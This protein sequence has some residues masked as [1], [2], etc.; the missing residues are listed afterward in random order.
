VEIERTRRG[1]AYRNMMKRF[2]VKAVLGGMLLVVR[3]KESTQISVVPAD[4]TRRSIAKE[5]YL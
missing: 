1:T 4:Q 3:G 5:T 2:S